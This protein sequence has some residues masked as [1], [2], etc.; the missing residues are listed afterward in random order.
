MTEIQNCE[1]N[2]ENNKLVCLTS[3]VNVTRYNKDLD[4]MFMGEPAYSWALPICVRQL[5]SK[6]MGIKLLS[7]SRKFVAL[8]LQHK[9]I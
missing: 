2:G 3:S 9:L 4:E 7:P 6:Y 1:I 8:C 5:L